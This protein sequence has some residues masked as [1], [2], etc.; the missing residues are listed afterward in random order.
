MCTWS[1]NV[2]PCLILIPQQPMTIFQQIPGI[3]S[4]FTQP[5]RPGHVREDLIELMMIQ[6]AQMHQVI[7]SNMTMAALTSFGFSPA[8]AAAQVN[9]VPLHT[10]DEEADL[11]FHHHYAPYPTATPAPPWQPLAQ[12]PAW[13]QEP[14]SIRHVGLDPHPAPAGRTQDDKVVPP[15]PPPS[16]TGTVGADVPPAAGKD[17]LL[18]PS[19]PLAHLL[20]AEV[21]VSPFQLQTNP[22]PLWLPPA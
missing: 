14:P 4:P 22:F 19:L 1:H 8:P 12:P 6:N 18:R 15:P 9:L 11:V 3:L 21:A 7:M 16:A 20:P 2:N 17:A 10:E 13:A 5:V